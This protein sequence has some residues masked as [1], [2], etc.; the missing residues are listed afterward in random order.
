MS[1]KLLLT[2]IAFVGITSFVETKIFKDRLP[3]LYEPA[4]AFP[5]VPRAF[6]LVVFV[7]T[8]FSFWLVTFGFK[9]STARKTCKESAEKDGETDLGKYDYPNLYAYGCSKHAIAFNSVQRAHQHALETIVQM[10]TATIFAA[11]VFPVSA[12]ISAFLWSYGRVCWATAYADQGK[13]LRYSHPMSIWIWRG[14]LANTILSIFACFA[15][16]FG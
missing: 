11:M 15:L 2:S 10:Y 6:G 13:D 4:P 8:C 1:T 9:V 3:Y 16:I 14:L 5:A 12:A 7:L